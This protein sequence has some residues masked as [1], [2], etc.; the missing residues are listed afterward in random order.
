MKSNFLE[1]LLQALK[2]NNEGPVDVER[3]V[4]TDLLDDYGRNEP[5]NEG[6]EAGRPYSWDEIFPRFDYPYDAGYGS[7][8]CHFIHMWTA[9]RV[10]YIHEYDGST[11]VESLP[12]N[13]PKKE[14][15]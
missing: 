15:K 10:Y 14:M 11:Y 12:R 13:P 1:D 6:I 4:V 2:E 3:V 9:D 5:R 8:D 7:A